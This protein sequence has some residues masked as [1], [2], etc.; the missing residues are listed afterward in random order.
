MGANRGREGRP[1]PWSLARGVRA[2][3]RERL[4]RA[5]GAVV[6]TSIEALAARL[7][8]ALTV[9]KSAGDA[10]ERTRTVL[11]IDRS[12]RAQAA[13]SARPAPPAP[14]PTVRPIAPV[15]EPSRTEALGA[16]DEPIRTRS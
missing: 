7:P 8:A 5:V 13:S 10:A 2:Q 12:T 6:A 1:G 9:P 16:C 4:E 15:Q 14:T 3:A 11:A